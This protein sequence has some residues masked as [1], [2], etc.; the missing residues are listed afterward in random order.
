MTM[1]ISTAIRRA[2]KI[3]QNFAR[4]LRFGRPLGGTIKTRYGHLGAH[5]VGNATYD[6]LAILFASIEVAR[7]DVLVDVGCGKGRSTNWFLTRF[8]EARIFGIELDPEICAGTAKRL[9]RH[10]NVTILC[11]DATTLLP[12]EGTIFYLF[13]PFDGNVMARFADAVHEGRS[14]RATKIAY[15][16]CKFLSVFEDDPRFSV[17]LLDDP[18]LSFRSAIVILV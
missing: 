16:N 4:D 3:V 10:R 14:G 15:L 9:R 1:K 13:N 5:D 11:G 2:P 6:D 17:R 18:R 8:P 7:S 12:A